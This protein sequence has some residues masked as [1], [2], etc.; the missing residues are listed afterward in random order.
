MLARRHL[1]SLNRQSSP[2]LSSAR[3]ESQAAAAKTSV[4]LWRRARVT[5]LAGTPLPLPPAGAAPRVTSAVPGGCWGTAAQSSARTQVR[6]PRSH[7][8]SA[9]VGPLPHMNIHLQLWRAATGL[10][11]GWRGHMAGVS[12]GARYSGPPL[13]HLSTSDGSQTLPAG[14]RMI[15]QGAPRSGPLPVLTSWRGPTMAPSLAPPI[16]LTSPPPFGGPCRHSRPASWHGHGCAVD[17]VHNGACAPR[18]KGGPQAPLGGLAGRWRRGGE[19][20]V[21]TKG[22]RSP[23]P[24]NTGGV[25]SGL[26]SADL[27]E[28]PPTQEVL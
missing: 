8:S 16:V 4:E 20:L 17:E 27:T 13:P 6:V 28:A 9:H 5:A 19:A 10:P 2:S 18:H 11:A 21:P 7:R 22:W 3:F 14:G 12:E 23:P 26:A 25:C 24:T 1:R 15:L